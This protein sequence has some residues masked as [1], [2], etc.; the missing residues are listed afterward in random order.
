MITTFVLV[1]V[2]GLLGWLWFFG[3]A[4]EDAA[5]PSSERAPGPTASLPGAPLEP[6]PRRTGAHLIVNLDEID[7]DDDEGDEDEDD[8]L[9]EVFYCELVGEQYD[10]RQGTI[11]GL[12]PDDVLLVAPE[13]ANPH[14]RNAVALRTPGGASV[15][16]L[17]RACAAVVA[18][19]M[20]ESGQ[21]VSAKVK[22][23][24]SKGGFLQVGVVLGF[25]L[26]ADEIG[27][28]FAP[29]L[30]DLI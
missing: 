4:Q 23:L 15:G 1:A 24:R 28:G 16:Y 27:D 9:G 3:G 7:L 25:G 20:R 29:R 30:E 18:R 8:L 5:Q 6:S 17:P 2:V 13:P 11:A 19:W 21:D 22:A 14:D 26:A 10:G 12:H